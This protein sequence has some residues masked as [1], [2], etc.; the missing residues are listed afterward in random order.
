MLE[1]SSSRN[2]GVEGSVHVGNDLWDWI[3]E[4]GMVEGATGRRQHNIRV[5]R[6]LGY[7][8]ASR[9]RFPEINL[10]SKTFSDLIVDKA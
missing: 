8:S 2:G 6:E 1:C 5:A 10:T 9:W 7:L 4:E 3:V